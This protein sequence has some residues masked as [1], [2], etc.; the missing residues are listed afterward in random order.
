MSPRCKID[1]IAYNTLR[2]T[3]G[4]ASDHSLLIDFPEI[5]FAYLQIYFASYPMYS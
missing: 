4:Q 2:M 1:I 3:S 5:Y